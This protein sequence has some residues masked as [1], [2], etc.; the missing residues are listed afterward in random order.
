M[1]C[2]TL[3]SA[4][5]ATVVLA[6]MTGSSALASSHS[7]APL[8]KLDPQ[9]N[10]TDVYAF[11]RQRPNG[12]KV[13][14]VEVNVHPFCEPGDGVVY[15]AFANDARYSIHITNHTTGAE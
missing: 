5:S 6:G 1:N 11:I 14:V 2:K 9:A 7:D 12:Q 4:L 10:L 3:L 13:L 8:I 15:D